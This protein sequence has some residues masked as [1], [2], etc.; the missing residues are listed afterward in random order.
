MTNRKKVYYLILPL[1]AALVLLPVSSL[2]A[3]TL[4]IIEEDINKAAGNLEIPDGTSVNGDVTLNLGEL[5]VAGV[6]NGN[7]KSNMG[8]VTID[9]Y[10]NGNVEANMGQVIINGNVAGDVSA[11][12]GEVVINGAVGG[13]LNAD[14]G[15]VNVG[16]SVGGDIGSG[17]GDLRVSGI[18]GGDINSRAGKVTITGIVEGDVTLDQGVVELGPDAVVSGKVYVGR[19]I[20]NKTA[21]TIVGSVEIEEEVEIADLQEPVPDEGYRFDGVDRDFADRIADRV[22]NSVEEALSRFEFIPHRMRSPHW[23]FLPLPFVGFQG[24]VARGVINMLIMFALAALTFTLF[25]RQVKK[26]GEAVTERTGPVVGWGI[27][28]AALAVPLMIVLAITI[29]GI[30][31]ILVEIFFLAAAAILGY[32]GIASLIGERVVGVSSS[33]SMNPFGSLAIGVLIIGLVS[34]IPVLG[35]LVSVAV[36]VLAIGAALVTRFG[37]NGKEQTITI[38]AEPK[39]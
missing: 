8:Q 27:L 36:F 29:I 21:T 20:V 37:T 13:N 25:P 9:G 7:V 22:V 12:M 4:V 6:V 26:V 31:L 18:V 35:W 17:F 15:A 14:L 11:R 39:D 1:L 24:S 30:P 38:S 5:V 10:V 28:A 33:A 19:G 3:S 16:G 23:P 2:T 34:L 32:T